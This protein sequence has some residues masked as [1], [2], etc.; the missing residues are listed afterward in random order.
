MT[1]VIVVE[2]KRI[3]R[4]QTSCN[5][6]LKLKAGV[7]VMRKTKE[8]ICYKKNTNKYY[9]LFH[10]V[11]CEEVSCNKFAENNDYVLIFLSP[12]TIDAFSFKPAFS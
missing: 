2:K 3:T 8:N 6:S 11:V 9:I 10:C 12:S 5:H 4:G 7:I 1:C